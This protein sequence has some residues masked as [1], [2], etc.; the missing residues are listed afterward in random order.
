M[1]VVHVVKVDCLVQK[2]LQGKHID[3]SFDEG[4]ALVL[5]GLQVLNVNRGIRVDKE[6]VV[7]QGSG[8]HRECG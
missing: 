7:R 8:R 2:R 6:G 1:S 4:G 3:V 5:N